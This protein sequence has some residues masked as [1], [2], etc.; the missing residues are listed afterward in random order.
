MN[1]PRSLRSRARRSAT[2]AGAASVLAALVAAC[3]PGTTDLPGSSVLSVAPV[4]QQSANT[5][6]LPV[7]QLA[8]RVLDEP[9]GSVLVDR[10]VPILPTDV[11]VEVEVALDIAPGEPVVVELA[12]RDAGVDVYAGGPVAVLPAE[13]P[14]P[15]PVRYVGEGEC[16]STVGDAPLGRLGQASGVATGR[17]D[18]GDCYLGGDDSFA[19]R[20]TL[21][22]PDDLGL[23]IDLQSVSGPPLR[24]RLESPSG[25]LVAGGDSDAIRAPLEGGSYV[26]VVTSADPLAVGDYRLTLGEYDR[27]DA[28]V[29]ML[30]TGSV[31][32]ESLERLDCPLSNGTSADLWEVE[33]PTDTPYR[34]DLES[35]AFDASLVL[36]DASAVDPLAS[37]ALDAD[38]DS[39]LGTNALL[40]GVLEPGRYRVWVSSFASGE[41]G[42]YQLSL[43]PLNP[44]APTVEVRAVRALG[45]GGLG[46]V[47]GSAQTFVF[48]FGFEDG[49]GDLVSPAGVTIRL[50]GIPSG[51]QELKTRDWGAFSGIGPYAGFA[52]LVTCETFLSGDSAKLAEF[53]VTDASGRSSAIFSTTLTPVSGTGAPPAVQSS[54]GR[55]R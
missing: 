19:D 42:A 15:I 30:T 23:D 8:L 50:T 25:A 22:V 51:F 54:G 37:E 46:G 52:E 36:T 43:Q 10:I 26:L 6:L 18:I 3:D 14:V 48:D 31:V 21:D 13:V 29:G 4:F 20:W 12:L 34:L 5:P 45:V 53:F 24:L 35:S 17:L 1:A 39:G 38:D 28:P 7:D 41:S 9:G 27:C 33:V 55:T 40:A 44:G 49:D 16:A 32:L 47:C 11:E 2:V